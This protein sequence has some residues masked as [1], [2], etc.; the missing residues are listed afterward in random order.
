MN[1]KIKKIAEIRNPSTNDGRNITF[2]TL[3]DNSL[4]DV[5]AIGQSSTPNSNIIPYFSYSNINIEEAF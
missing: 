4:N 5:K 3:L 2:T 1:V